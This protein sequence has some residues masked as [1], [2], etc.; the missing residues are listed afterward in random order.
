M[1]TSLIGTRRSWGG[2]ID[3]EGHREYTVQFRVRSTSKNDGPET[4]MNT[5]GLPAVGAVWNLGNDSDSWAFCYPDMKVSLAEVG[6]YYFWDVEQKFSTKPLKRCNTTQIEDPLSEPQKVSGSFAKYTEEV[7]YDRYGDA[8][9]SSS[10]EPYKGSE[11]EFD[12]NRPTVRI[13]QNVAALGLSTFAAMI[14]TVND[15]PLWG[16]PA[17][18]V[19]LSN[20]GWERKLYGVCTYYF[21]RTFDFDV[22]YDGF[23]RVLLDKGTRVIRGEWDRRYRLEDGTYNPTYGRYLCKAYLAGNADR[24][25]P[26]LAARS[27]PQNFVQYKDWNGE[28]TSVVLDGYG[29]PA[30]RMV[31]V[32][33]GTGTGTVGE[34]RG[35]VAIAFVERY[36]E[37]NFLELGI[38]SSFS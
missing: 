32:G 1:S 12:A 5:A 22:R 3:S 20:V 36:G 35:D 31:P 10:L 13:E 21:A 24:T 4:V 17:R 34:Q 25:R 18:C 23:D 14:D 38:P 30:I 2:S 7:F 28:N 11:V 19:K 8:I 16:L 29:M 27:N 9:L 26:S 6:E 33:T 37:S 15:A